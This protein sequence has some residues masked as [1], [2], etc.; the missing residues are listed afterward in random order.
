MALEIEIKPQEESFFQRHKKAILITGS[1]LIT[2]ALI[3]WKRDAILNCLSPLINKGPS[4]INVIIPVTED[5]LSV[6]IL[7]SSEPLCIPDKL[8]DI[9]VDQYLRNLPANQHASEEKLQLAE[10]L[11]ILLEDGKTI[12]NSYDYSRRAA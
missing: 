9:H 12:V 6:P 4:T 10:A 8:L 3:Y 5:A 7:Q 11:G 2:A 1:G